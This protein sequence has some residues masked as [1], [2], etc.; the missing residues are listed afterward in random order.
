MTENIFEILGPVTAMAFLVG[1]AAWWLIAMHL[2]DK[3]YEK[4]RNEQKL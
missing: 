4:L 2:Q 1:M 3:K